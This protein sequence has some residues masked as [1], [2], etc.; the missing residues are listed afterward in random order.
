VKDKKTIYITRFPFSSQLGGE[1]LHTMAI[2]RH[3]RAMGHKVVFLTSCE[4]LLDLAKEDGFETEKAWLYKPPVTLWSLIIFTILSP[5]LFFHA[6]GIITRLKL[7]D[8]KCVFYMLSFTEKLIMTPFLKATLTPVIWLEHARIGNWFWKNPWKKWYLKLADFVKVV[9]VSE[10]MIKDL[11]VKDAILIPNA[12]KNSYFSKIRDAEVL[13][14]S[15]KAHFL[16][17][18]LEVGYVGRLTADKGMSLVIEAAKKLP[19]L[20]F[21]T[22]GEGPMK[23]ELK[24]AGVNVHDKIN[25]EQ[26]VAFM[27][28]IDIF[29]LPSTEV[30]PFGL[31][32]LEAMAAGTPVVLTNK[33]GV[34]DY[35]DSGKDAIVAT[36]DEFIGALDKL[37]R[38]ET[39]RKKL[40]E[41][42][43]KTV[44][45]K[46]KCENMLEAY[47]ELID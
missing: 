3:Y 31:V 15:L 30:D 2:A 13:P 12:I 33:C 26:V 36:V 22:V 40:S 5:I 46:F 20:N 9:T 25:R 11:G 37:S 38:S 8:R 24:K 42:G 43:Q 10:R 41:H 4:V 17:A 6:S 35:L 14:D 29:I 32:V 16:P 23:S 21:V 27:Q 7:K 45:K 19:G 18:Q 34:A 47:G 44:E 28:N 1:E 39:K